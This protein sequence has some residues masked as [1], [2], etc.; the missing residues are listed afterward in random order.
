M[1]VMDFLRGQTV[2]II[3]WLDDTNDTLAWRFPG[4][5]QNAVK[6]GAQ[7]TVREGQAAVFINEG[8]LA[9][10]FGPGMFRLITRTLPILS[11]L[12]GWAY[13]FESPFKSDVI[14][15][16]TRQFTD[17]KWGTVNPVMMR[18]AEFG[19]IRLRARGMYSFKVAD[20]GLFIKEIVGTDGEFTTEDINGQLR[21]LVV[22][23]F[24]DMLAEAKVPALD[25]AT[26]Y[27]E[28][29]AQGKDKMLGEFTTHG[30]NLIKFVVEE[31]SLPP[32]VEKV[33]DKKTSMGIIGQG[34]MN[35]F[36][37]FQAGQAMEAG[38]ANPGGEGGMGMGMG[39]GAGVAMGQM[40][41]Q[42]MQGGAAGAGAAPAAAAGA[43]CVHCGVV[44]PAGSKFCP[45]CGKPAAPPA[46][47]DTKFCTQC[48]AANPADAKFCKECG[49]PL[50][51]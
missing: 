23:G 30:L 2:D 15:I 45:G 34:N 47:A 10:V 6:Y 21:A 16:S 1:G 33:L 44:V 13:G 42:S 51:T 8:K 19:P 46:Q 22:S 11:K 36:L 4:T 26:Q 32:E 48:G 7:L 37:Q 28:L 43:P 29:S 14:F 50:T 18:D 17:Q 20:P 31:I 40:I 12:Q 5:H 35:Q 38:A 3:E 27:D 39:L 24:T 41:A 9:D 25:L 49:A